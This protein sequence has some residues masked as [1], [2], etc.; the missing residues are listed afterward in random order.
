MGQ[1][2]YTGLPYP[3]SVTSYQPLTHRPQPWSCPR[4]WLDLAGSLHDPP[5][6]P[7][8]NSAKQST[9][10][11]ISTQLNQYT[12]LIGEPAPEA[13]IG[14]HP[15]GCPVLSAELRQVLCPSA[16]WPGHGS[17]SPPSALSPR[18]Q[19]A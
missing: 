18:Q 17:D 13:K 1:R 11:A 12:P 5:G 8:Q 3:G 4:L 19:E 6:T 16:C 14:P 10:R 15:S 7:T 9:A 2:K